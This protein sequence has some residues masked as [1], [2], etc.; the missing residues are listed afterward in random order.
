[1]K[2][3]AKREG[4]HEGGKDGKSHRGISLRLGSASTEPPD[5]CLLS[6]GL[7]ERDKAQPFHSVKLCLG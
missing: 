2:G 6:R 1:M 4:G 5:L 7:R 3:E